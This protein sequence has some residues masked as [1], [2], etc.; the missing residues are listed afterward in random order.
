MITINVMKNVVLPKRK[1]TNDKTN[2]NYDKTRLVVT[3]M[4]SLNRLVLDFYVNNILPNSV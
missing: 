2:S 3:R 1:E 4:F